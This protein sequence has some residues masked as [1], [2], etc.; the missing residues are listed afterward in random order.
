MHICYSLISHIILY[1]FRALNAHYQENSLK[2]QA[3]WY[4]IYPRMWW[5]VCL[6]CVGTQR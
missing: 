6:H 5:M 4:N 1:M 2:I 3:L